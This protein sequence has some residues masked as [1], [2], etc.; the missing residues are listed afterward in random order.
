MAPQEQPTNEGTGDQPKNI[1]QQTQDTEQTQD[2]RDTRNTQQTDLT[3]A[4]LAHLGLASDT[5]SAG[6]FGETQARAEARTGNLRPRLLP[7]HPPHGKQFTSRD[8]VADV[9]AC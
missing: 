2:T 7:Q 6:G 8:A 3:H 9:F 5:A 4:F 1:T